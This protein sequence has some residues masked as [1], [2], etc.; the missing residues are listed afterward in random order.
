VRYRDALAS[1][2]EVPGDD[3]A[4]HHVD[5]RAI[6]RLARFAPA[7]DRDTLMP[8]YVRDPDAVRRPRAGAA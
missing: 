2:A 1:A 6:C 5:A 7:A 4:R 8:D 3:D